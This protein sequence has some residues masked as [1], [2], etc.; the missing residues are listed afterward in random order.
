MELENKTVLILGLGISGVSTVKALNKLGA[1][2]I[3]SD[4]KKKEELE[5]FLEDISPYPVK[6]FLGTNDIPL[7]NV[8]LI[9]KSPGIPFDIPIIEKAKKLDIEVINDLELAYR[10]IPKNKFIAITGTNGKTTTTT[11]TGEIFKKAGY[12]CHITGNI[13]VGILWEAVN[14]KEEDIFIVE[15]SSFQLESTE[16]FK[17][18]VSTILNITPDHINWHKSY[19]NYS[20]CKKKIFKSQDDTD[21]T[22][23]NYDDEILRK[24]KDSIN[25]N[26]IWFSVNN[27]LDDGVYIDGED[28]VIKD[29]EE[30][31]KVLPWKE[32]KMP[33][34][35]NLENVLSSIAISWS[36][37][38]DI[39]VIEDVLKNFEG[40]EHRIEYVTSI[41]GIKF[42]NDSKGTNP[43]SSIEAIKALED[44]IILIAGGK[45][46]E[47]DFDEFVEVFKGRLKY[48]ILLGETSKKIKETAIKH[49]FNN[50]YIV[51]SIKEAVNKSFQLGNSGDKILLSPAC[52]SWDMYKS[53]EERGKD[54]KKAVYSLKED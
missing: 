33:G 42:Y 49:G 30:A 34:K 26:I 32:V 21:F 29:G 5:E 19:K 31:I 39:E 11:L 8:D 47:S 1:D 18:K 27:K 25:S 10:I 9:V 50:I 17:P 38:I 15:A 54:F 51:G 6:L 24:S 40:L 23:L 20:D 13:G 22:V 46:K 41:K 28:I 36:M 53:F 4:L 45:D 16:K 37:G 48:L 35:H 43:V 7:N 52:A 12:S 44:S 3:I 14:S 2:I